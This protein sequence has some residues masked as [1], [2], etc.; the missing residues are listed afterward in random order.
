MSD[1][2]K[3]GERVL[4]RVQFLSCGASIRMNQTNQGGGISWRTCRADAHQRCAEHGPACD[5]HS[6]L[7]VIA[8]GRKCDVCKK[9]MER[10]R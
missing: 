6:R 3:P 2:T 7:D 5:L 4:R 10:V 8:G 1:D 9:P